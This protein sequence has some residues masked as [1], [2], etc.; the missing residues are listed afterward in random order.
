MGAQVSFHDYQGDGWATFSANNGGT[1]A[2]ES[3]NAVVSCGEAPNLLHSEARQNRPFLGGWSGRPPG[4]QSLAP[5]QGAAVAVEVGQLIGPV[6]CESQFTFY[7]EDNGGGFA[8]D[9]IH[10]EFVVE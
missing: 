8:T 2:L 6:P 4:D 5:G 1:I 9:V 3:M 10:V 7:S